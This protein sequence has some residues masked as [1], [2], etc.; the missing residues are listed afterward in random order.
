[1]YLGKDRG[2]AK[3]RSSLVRMSFDGFLLDVSRRSFHSTHSSVCTH[4]SISSGPEKIISTRC[5]LLTHFKTSLFN[6][7]ST[8]ACNNFF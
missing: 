2:N 5:V 4:K 7:Q 8:R 1:M 6:K 3:M